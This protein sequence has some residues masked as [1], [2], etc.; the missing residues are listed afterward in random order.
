MPDVKELAS[1]HGPAPESTESVIRKSEF[2]RGAERRLLKRSNSVAE[3]VAMFQRQ[4]SD[5]ESCLAGGERPCSGEG[6]AGRQSEDSRTQRRSQ[7][8]AY[9]RVPGSPSV[10][11][12]ARAFSRRGRSEDSRSSRNRATLPAFRTGPDKL[13]EDEGGI[14]RGMTNVSVKEGF[15][16]PRTP[17]RGDVIG[18]ERLE[19]HTIT[20]GTVRDSLADRLNLPMMVEDEHGEVALQLDNHQTVAGSSTD[21]DTSVDSTPRRTDEELGSRTSSFASPFNSTDCGSARDPGRRIAGG[22]GLKSAD[23]GTTNHGVNAVHAQ[24]AR[25]SV[26]FGASA[27]C[28]SIPN[29]GRGRPRGLR[30]RARSLSSTSSSSNRVPVPKFTPNRPSSLGHGEDPS[31]FRSIV[32]DGTEGADQTAFAVAQQVAPGVPMAV[33]IRAAVKIESVMRVLIARGYVRRKLVSEVTAFSLIMERGIEVIKV[34]P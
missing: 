16:P 11:E 12:M 23:G 13:Q 2:S 15:S 26:P 21:G 33:V 24:D 1:S 17:P 28:K 22:S 32:S 18:H 3:R 14:V 20:D 19:G 29:N 30:P 34:G 31:Q 4:A 27:L 8:V 6:V 7:E 10:R 5:V 25:T 9:R